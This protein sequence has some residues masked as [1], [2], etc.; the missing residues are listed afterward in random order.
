MK[1]VSHQ[2]SFFGEYY[3]AMSRKAH[4]RMKRVGGPVEGSDKWKQ[5][6]RECEE[7]YPPDGLSC[8]VMQGVF[9]CFGDLED[10]AAS[11]T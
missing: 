8:E 10:D 6:R 2:P 4:R 9:V 3:P 11:G 5:N 1:V 7:G